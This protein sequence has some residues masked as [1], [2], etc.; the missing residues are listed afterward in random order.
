MDFE[1]KIKAVENGFVLK[2]CDPDIEEENR[3]G[4]RWADPEKAY[5]FTDP[6]DA[7]KVLGSLLDRVVQGPEQEK[8]KM[9]FDA[10]FEEAMSNGK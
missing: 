7:M 5:V 1:V 8:Q 3:K 6:K 2:Y 9:G 4:D 10:A